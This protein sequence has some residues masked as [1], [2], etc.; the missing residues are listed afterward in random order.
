MLSCSSLKM[1]LD[2]LSNLTSEVIDQILYKIPIKEAVRT[3]VLSSVWRYKWAT[4]SHLVF[5]ERCDSTLDHSAFVNIVDRILLLHIGP[6]HKFKLSHQEL[7][8]TSDIDRWIL[9]LSRHSIKEFILDVL[10]GSPY[11][12][13]SCLFS[14]QD[15]IH[16]ELSTC[17]LEPPPAF[18]GFR[19]LKRL[20][21]QYVT[22]TQDVLI[23]CCPLLE[24]LTLMNW[25]GFTLLKIDAPNLR[26][27]SVDGD[28][29]EVILKNTS[30]L[31]D[32]TIC[33][34]FDD[35][36]R[37][38][39]SSSNLLNFFAH[40]PQIQSLRL[41]NCFL[42]YLAVGALPTNQLP[43]PCLFLK[44][45]CIHIW[46]GSLEEILTVLCLMRSSPALEELEL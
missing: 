37:F 2:E 22:L 3:C 33:L 44:F 38:L 35:E 11:K 16:L 1:E 41:R 5:D 24:T 28:F 45:L 40:L 43:I 36:G 12:I 19:S 17:L 21:M 27:L 7:A 34:Y 8:A 42:E 25:K 23:L 29:E 9:H 4:L 10:K 14:C 32:V 6:I 20:D 13:P 31:V 39:R 15:I 46:L 30:N 26:F 18:K